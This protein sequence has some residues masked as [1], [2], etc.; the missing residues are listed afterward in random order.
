[1]SRVILVAALDSHAIFG[2]EK[3]DQRGLS[4]ALVLGGKAGHLRLGVDRDDLGT[5]EDSD[6]FPHCSPTISF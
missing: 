1:M 3:C 6:R 5:N 2:P 4:I